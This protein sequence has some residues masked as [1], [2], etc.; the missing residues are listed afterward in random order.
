MQVRFANAG[1]S[2][3]VNIDP[4]KFVM[5]NVFDNE[6]YGWYDQEF[7]SILREDYDNF[8]AIYQLV[9]EEKPEEIVRPEEIVYLRMCHKLVEVAKSKPGIIPKDDPDMSKILS[10][11]EVLEDCYPDLNEKIQA[12]WGKQN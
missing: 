11:I 5:S 8:C 4:S 6:V 7:I 9:E 12:K 1:S 3:P 2:H 10:A